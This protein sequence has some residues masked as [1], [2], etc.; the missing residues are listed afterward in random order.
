MARPLKT[1][2][3]ILD[4]QSFE[5]SA[6]S[7]ANQLSGILTN[8]RYE[9]KLRL[10]GNLKQAQGVVS[11]LKRKLAKQFELEEKVLFPFLLRYIPKLEVAVRLL[12]AEHDEFQSQFKVFQ[13]Y[14]KDISKGRARREQISER[15]REVGMYL[16]YLL[17]NHIEAE[18]MMVY[19]PLR[20]NLKKNEK[21][22]LALQIEKAIER[23]GC[24][25]RRYQINH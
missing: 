21:K 5:T 16:V 7:K 19:K 20:S 22:E 8:L 13:K 12:E 23:D 15:L 4:L 6:L 9:G 10:G 2:S 25:K 1:Y 3:P 17:R 11:F 18:K 14:L 24:E